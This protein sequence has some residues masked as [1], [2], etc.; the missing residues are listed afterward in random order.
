LKERKVSRAP[1][2]D[3]EFFITINHHHRSIQVRK[4]K[5]ITRK[6]V[7]VQLCCVFVEGCCCVEAMLRNCDRVGITPQNHPG[8]VSKVCQLVHIE[9]KGRDHYIRD[10]RINFHQVVMCNKWVKFDSRFLVVCLDFDA[11]ICVTVANLRI[12][13]EFEFGKLG[14]DYINSSGSECMRVFF[15]WILKTFSGD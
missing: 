10:S 14:R 5:Q 7:V 9:C 6:S 15:D 4:S 2:H 8:W 12:A 1:Y 11:K 13:V 3:F